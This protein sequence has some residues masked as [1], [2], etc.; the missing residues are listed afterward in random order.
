MLRHIEILLVSVFVL[1][2]ALEYYFRPQSQTL[3]QI[4]RSGE[5]RVLI[6]DE[7]DS[8][9][10]FNRQH[11]GFEYE[12]LARYAENLGVE[13]KLSVVPYGEIFT[14]LQGG[15]GDIAVG[16][17]VESGFVDRVSQPTMP[18][19]RAKTAVVYQRGTPPPSSVNDFQSVPVKAAARY[20]EI[21]VLNEINL[22]DDHRTEYQLLSDVG[23][24][25]ERYVLSTD[26]RTLAAKHYLPNL[27]RSFVLP[28]K[29]NI[30]WALP[31]RYDPALLVSVN[32]F[33]RQAVIE[34]LPERL[35]DAYFRSPSRLSTYDVLAVHRNIETVLP[36]LEYA[37]R[38][39]ARRGDIDWQ[40]LA[41]ISY[42]ESHWR[43]DA[44]SPTGVRG[45]MQL[46]TETAT[47]LGVED[48]MDMSKTIDAAA[49]Y[50]KQ[51]RDRLPK[52][53]NEPER[54]WFA[55]GAYN[56]GLKHVL[57]AYNKALKEGKDATRW[58]TIGALLPQ[59]YGE[60]FPQGSQ[61]KKYVERVQIF[62]DIL[63][64][65]DLHLRPEI[66]YNTVEALVPA[67][68]LKSAVSYVG[69]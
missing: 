58:Q 18:W 4:A 51:L 20:Y 61:A 40:L 3:Q 19:Y 66:D 2:A 15:Q 60:P 59:L 7:P 23:Q 42:Q 22:Q 50:I 25:K 35:A 53:I 41:A 5:L 24:G 11:Y 52:S 63:R 16:G 55:V 69:P 65:Y 43:N 45:I 8:Q 6:A 34:G 62:T 12:L 13:L 21:D 28:H 54:T 64:F 44:L 32:A 38:R 30:V 46:T 39:A 36:G 67:P 57:N 29:V 56:V 47:H 49:I 1:I 27:N 9:F 17:I 14:L 10:V 33:L 26:Y 31:K 37:F 68:G 48:R